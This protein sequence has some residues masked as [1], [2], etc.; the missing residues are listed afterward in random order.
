MQYAE[1]DFPR[2]L[3]LYLKASEAGYDLAQANAAWM[4]GQNQGIPSGQSARDF[5]EPGL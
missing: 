3:M 5:V 4:L 1:G 2:A